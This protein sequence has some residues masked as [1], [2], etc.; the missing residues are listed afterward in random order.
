MSTLQYDDIVSEE[1][2]SST[3]DE[4]SITND[5]NGE[6]DSAD[7]MDTGESHTSG[8]SDD[9]ATGTSVSDEVLVG[10]QPGEWPYDIPE[11]LEYDA[12]RV[13]SLLR[14]IE[15]STDVRVSRSVIE[16]VLDVATRMQAILQLP[17]STP[18]SPYP[19]CMTPPNLIGE[20]ESSN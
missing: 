3:E 13:I 5:D 10:N 1:D 14:P 8:D 2:F 19:H 6:E 9:D 7:T 16:W 4:E 11:D 15:G 17:P 18:S 12:P 20:G